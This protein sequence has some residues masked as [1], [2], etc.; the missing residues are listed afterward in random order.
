ML[1]GDP[2]VVMGQNKKSP[3]RNIRVPC[4]GSASSLAMRI[5]IRFTDIHLFQGMG[6]GITTE[7][8]WARL[9]AS[10]V[11]PRTKLLFRP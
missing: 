10:M 1:S 6:L 3:G 8:L 2:R 9:T 11:V 7:R 5:S 4:V